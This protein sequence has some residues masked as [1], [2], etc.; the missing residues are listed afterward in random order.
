MNPDWPSRSHLLPVNHIQYALPEHS[1]LSWI[2]GAIWWLFYSIVVKGLCAGM[3]VHLSER[4]VPVTFSHY[5][6]VWIQQPYRRIS[7]PEAGFN[8][9]GLALLRPMAGEIRDNLPR[10]G[11]S[12]PA[13]CI[14]ALAFFFCALNLPLR[15]LGC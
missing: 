7:A 12:R 3:I 2:H 15:P 13:H 10:C 8:P 1:L 4:I 5:C 9:D 11:A 6:S 14:S